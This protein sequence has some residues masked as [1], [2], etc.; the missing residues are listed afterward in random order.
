V[1]DRYSVFSPCDNQ[2]CADHDRASGEGVGPQEYTLIRMEVMKLPASLKALE[3]RTV[4]MLAATLRYA[5][6]M[7]SCS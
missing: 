3:G 5:M 7:C 2:I 6:T 1:C 4:V